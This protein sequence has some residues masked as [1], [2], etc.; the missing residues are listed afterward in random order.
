MK[1]ILNLLFII[2]IIVTGLGV[3]ELIHITPSQSI[4]ITILLILIAYIQWKKYL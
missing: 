4:Q 1:I 3:F 2:L